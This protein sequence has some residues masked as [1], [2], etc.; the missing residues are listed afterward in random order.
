MNAFQND[1]GRW[2]DRTGIGAAIM[3]IIVIDGLLD[4]PT[5]FQVRQLACHELR[6]FADRIIIV[7][8]CNDGLALRV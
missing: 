5:R 2:F 4:G 3:A 8:A 6:L 7:D 1:N